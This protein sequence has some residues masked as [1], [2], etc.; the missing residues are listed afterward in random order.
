MT[1]KIQFIGTNDLFSHLRGKSFD[2]SIEYV[3]NDMH[4][5]FI[6]AENKFMLLDIK[7]CMIEDGVQLHGILQDGDSVG[8]VAIQLS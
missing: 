7:G 2:C 4:Q 6:P 5:I 1:T 8:R 3:G